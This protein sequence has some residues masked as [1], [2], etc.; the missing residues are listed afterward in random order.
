MS[1][2][3]V[4]DHEQYGESTEFSSLKEAMSALRDCGPDFANVTLSTRG[5]DIVNE[6][7]EVVGYV[8][9]AKR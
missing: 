7:R 9:S 3:F 5:R 8:L 2:I 1:T 4:I 6:C